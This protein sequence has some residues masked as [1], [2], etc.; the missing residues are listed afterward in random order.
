MESARLQF[1]MK[2]EALYTLMLQ[3]RY[4]ALGHNIVWDQTAEVVQNMDNLFAIIM[5]TQNRDEIAQIQTCL[6]QMVQALVQDQRLE[7][8]HPD[9]LAQWQALND[10]T[11]ALWGRAPVSATPRICRSAH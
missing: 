1:N 11:L 6:Q 4:Q 9:G 2:Y 3:K 10:L 7:P 8:G 5:A